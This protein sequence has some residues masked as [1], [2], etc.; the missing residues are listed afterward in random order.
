[1]FELD[2][3]LAEK[4]EASEKFARDNIVILCQEMLEWDKTGTLKDGK[5]REL[6]QLCS[7][8]GGSNALRVARLLVG[9][10]AMEAVAKS[11]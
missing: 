11:A 3:K 5:S 9:T 7:Y 6:E 4:R 10:I 2:D 8:A 1:M